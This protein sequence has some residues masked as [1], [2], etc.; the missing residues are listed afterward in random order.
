MPSVLGINFNEAFEAYL[1]DNPDQKLTEAD[2]VN[3]ILE[4]GE[5]QVESDSGFE[6]A[7]IIGLHLVGSILGLI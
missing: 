4:A 7:V 1:A 5:C 6:D 3:E 2:L